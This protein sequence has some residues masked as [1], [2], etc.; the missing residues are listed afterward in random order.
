M[1]ER[2]G[3]RCGGEDF[4]V[5]RSK[6]GLLVPDVWEP[7]AEANWR[8]EANISSAVLHGS[9]VLRQCSVNGNLVYHQM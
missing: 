2:R 3:V 5:K 4:R 8:S 9:T 7:E 1:G 6:P